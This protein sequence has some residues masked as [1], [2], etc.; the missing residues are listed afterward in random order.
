LITTPAKAKYIIRTNIFLPTSK[1]LPKGMHKRKMLE[2]DYEGVVD[3]SPTIAL[4]DRSSNEKGFFISSPN[5]VEIYTT[6]Y[7]QEQDL[8]YTDNVTLENVFD[9]TDLYDLYLFDSAKVMMGWV[10]KFEQ[11]SE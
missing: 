1:T 6:W 10:F 11:E 7:S 9:Q 8:F 5:S 3:N 4:F 2:L